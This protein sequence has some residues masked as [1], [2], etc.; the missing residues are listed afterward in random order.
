VH[1]SYI[2]HAKISGGRRVNFYIS[3]TGQNVPSYTA[4]VEDGTGQQDKKGQL[5]YTLKHS[6]KKGQFNTMLTAIGKEG[7]IKY[8]IKYLMSLL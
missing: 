5:N 2:F 1:I 6:A 8:H 3:T 7:T 4:W